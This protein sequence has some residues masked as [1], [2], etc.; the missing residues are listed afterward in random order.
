MKKLFTLVLNF[1]LVVC[2]NLFG[3][4][5]FSTLHNDISISGFE[6][7]VAI[8]GPDSTVWFGGNKLIQFDGNDFIDFGLPSCNSSLCNI[9][10]LFF[11][12]N[13]TLWLSGPGI[14]LNQFVNGSFENIPGP[15]DTQFPDVFKGY[16]N[17]KIVVSSSGQIRA[18][19]NNFT[20]Y[21]QNH[22]YWDGST[23]EQDGVVFNQFIFQIDLEIAEGDTIFRVWNDDFTYGSF[24][25]PQWNY[26]INDLGIINQPSD[27]SPMHDGTVVMLF[28]TLG[29]FEIV[30]K[31][32]GY[33]QLK[34]SV[35]NA[36][37]FPV[38]ICK[39]YDSNY[40]LL[41]YHNILGKLQLGFFNGQQIIYPTATDLGLSNYEL[42]YMQ[43]IAT[44]KKKL[45]IANNDSNA[46]LIEIHLDGISAIEPDF[47]GENEKLSF[48]VSPN[49]VHN[50][51]IH[52][53]VK[54]LEMATFQIEL[55]G[56][57]GRLHEQRH[58]DSLNP[59]VHE[60]DF[61]VNA[62]GIYLVSFYNEGRVFREK[63][64]V[65]D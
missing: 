29:S 58:Q 25:D 30:E 44:S 13:G 5:F 52:L 4:D 15:S 63:V 27:F 7:T 12:S 9:Q 34:H 61:N 59:A 43:P 64:V 40:W 8:E 42:A 62:P 11:D 38:S 3:Q 50:R 51:E 10:T 2:T 45:W 46:P 14:G 19:F 16:E 47:V 41:V 21:S 37:R 65:I 49:P 53:E 17:Q 26:N 57:D 24:G 28:A 54:S 33:W 35:S 36:N 23:W 6:P 32:L 18:Y 60:F 55:R 31:N 56:M 20:N 22:V 48:L 1:L 39:A